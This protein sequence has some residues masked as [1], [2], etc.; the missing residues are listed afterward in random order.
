ML[1][2][3]SLVVLVLQ[4]QVANSLWPDSDHLVATPKRLACCIRVHHVAL[5]SVTLHYSQSRFT[6]VNHVVSGFGASSEPVGRF[7]DVYHRE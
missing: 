5:E 2:V 6:I 1:L 7:V 3:R 4:Q